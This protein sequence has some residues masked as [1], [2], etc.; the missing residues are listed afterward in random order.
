[1]TDWLDSLTT[2]GPAE[3]EAVV[4]AIARASS[5]AGTK[6]QWDGYATAAL[7]ADPLRAALIDVVRAG[8]RMR[9]TAAELRRHINPEKGCGYIVYRDVWDASSTAEIEY[10]AALVALKG[11]VE[12]GG[13]NV[14]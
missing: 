3:I 2:P 7:T 11:L 13:V 8:E 5:R 6:A 14:M 1:M 9:E 12:G 10:N 4:R